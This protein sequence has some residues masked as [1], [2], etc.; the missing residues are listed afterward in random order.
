MKNFSYA[1]RFSSRDFCQELVKYIPDFCQEKISESIK[2]QAWYPYEWK[3]DPTIQ[4]M[5]IMIDAIHEKFKNQQNLWKSL[6][7]HKNISFYFLPLTEMGLTDDLYIKMNSR[8][9]PL[10]P[11][12]HFKAEFE[13]IIRQHSEELSKEINHKFDIEWTDML[14]PFRG[15]NNIIDHHPGQRLG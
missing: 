15:D 2:D 6:V 3:N 4:S 11:F 10:T 12:E 7:T 14:F 1:T 5:L 9:K 13:E 8:G